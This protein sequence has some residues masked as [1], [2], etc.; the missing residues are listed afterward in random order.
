MGKNG[1]FH[2]RRV[3]QRRVKQATHN[4]IE[5]RGSG[6]DIWCGKVPQISVWPFL[7][8]R[9][10]SSPVNHNSGTNQGRPTTSSCENAALDSDSADV[11]M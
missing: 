2:L 4:N 3:H 8:S 10:L 9:D 5:E 1:Q 11:L 6:H 7:H